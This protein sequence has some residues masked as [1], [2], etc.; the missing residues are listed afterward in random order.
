MTCIVGLVD[1][2]NIWMGGDSAGV[3]GYD[4]RVRADEKVFIKDKF[5]MGFTSSFRMGQIL[6]YKL[7]IPPYYPE[8]DI[9]K[10][11]VEDFID[12]VRKCFKESGYMKTKDAVEEGGTFLVGFRGTLFEVE[13]DLQVGVIV[14]PYNACGCGRSYALGSL[15]TSKGSPEDRIQ[16]AL[17]VAEEFSAGVRKPFHILRLGE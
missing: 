16:K 6:R 14:A 4:L 17:E 8:V 13:D 9:W 2:N 5:I 3:G 1:G 12:A 10:Y 15:A 11:M 7:V